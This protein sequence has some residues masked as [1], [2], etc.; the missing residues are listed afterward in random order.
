MKSYYI[1]A[2]EN[3]KIEKYKKRSIGKEMANRDSMP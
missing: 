1:T 2:I 3:M